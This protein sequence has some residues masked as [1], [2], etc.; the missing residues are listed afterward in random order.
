M[1]NNSSGGVDIYELEEGLEAHW[2]VNFSADLLHGQVCSC[3][4]FVSV[5]VRA[6]MCVACVVLSLDLCAQVH[7]WVCET[8]HVLSELSDRSPPFFLRAAHQFKKYDSDG[9]G[10]ISAE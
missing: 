7:A 1:D 9:S 3:S 10:F 6:C 2:H 8:D 4:A 5:R